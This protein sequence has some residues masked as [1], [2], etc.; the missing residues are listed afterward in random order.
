[1]EH[2]TLIRAE[3]NLFDLTTD[4]PIAL[5]QFRMHQKQTSQQNTQRERKSVSS[6]RSLTATTGAGEEVGLEPGGDE[7]SKDAQ[8]RCDA[9]SSRRSVVPCGRRCRQARRPIRRC[10]SCTARWRSRR[11]RRGDGLQASSSCYLSRVLQPD[12]LLLLLLSL[13]L[14]WF[15]DPRR[16]PTD[17]GPLCLP[18]S[19]VAWPINLARSTLLFS[20]SLPS[21]W[22]STYYAI[23]ASCN[24]DDPWSMNGWG[25]IGLESEE[26]LD[27]K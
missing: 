23:A 14:A 17:P 12:V 20:L 4:W 27:R 1:M 15:S 18:W 7:R 2:G 9:R 3:P 16:P 11:A 5:V 6:S 13:R 10:W 24:G 8:I 22:R 21:V 19:L 26:T 25:W